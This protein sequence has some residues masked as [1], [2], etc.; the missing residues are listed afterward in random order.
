[1]LMRITTTIPMT[2][3]NSGHDEQQQQ[4]IAMI[5]HKIKVHTSWNIII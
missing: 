2:I 1:M 4:P 3:D 5:L